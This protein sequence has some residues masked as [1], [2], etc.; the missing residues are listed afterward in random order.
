MRNIISPVID[1]YVELVQVDVDVDGFVIVVEGYVAVDPGSHTPDHT[2][3]LARDHGTL[4]EGSKQRINLLLCASKNN[5]KSVENIP[6][7]AQG[8]NRSSRDEEEGRREERRWGDGEWERRAFFPAP[9]LAQA[10]RRYVLGPT[11]RPT[12]HGTRRQRA[13]QPWPGRAGTERDWLGRG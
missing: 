1:H 13:A 7:H 9:V 3:A 10:L 12:G 4:R 8:K 6:N 5:R 2:T 11:V